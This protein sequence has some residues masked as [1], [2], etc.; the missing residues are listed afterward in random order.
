MG[1]CPNIVMGFFGL[2][3]RSQIAQYMLN[4]IGYNNTKNFEGGYNLFSAKLLAEETHAAWR[5][6]RAAHPVEVV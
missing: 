3:R 1:S 2:G 6:R 4:D 5:A